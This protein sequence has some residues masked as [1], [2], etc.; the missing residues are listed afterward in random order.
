[1]SGDHDAENMNGTMSGTRIGPYL[2]LRDQSGL[3]H[4]ARINSVSL[5]SEID[6]IGD[7]TL[8][9][10]SSRPI[11]LS[12]TIDEVLGWLGVEP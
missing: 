5:V 10:I 12:A 3:R 7:E 8:M 4:L 9:V 6:E 1:M 11:R 2:L